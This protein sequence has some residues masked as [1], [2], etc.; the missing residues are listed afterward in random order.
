[1]DSIRLLGISGSPRKGAT[2]FVVRQA[3]EFAESLGGVETEFISLKG[4]K[5]NFCLHCDYCVR[6]KK[7]CIQKDDVS[8]LYPSMEAAD[9]W[10]L[11]TPVY[12]G[13]VSGQLKAVLDRC[14]AVVA[15]NPDVFRNKVG[16]AIAV[17]GDRIGGQEPAIMAIHA[18]YL[19]NKMI[20][21]SGGPYGSNLGGTVWS[22]DKKAEGAA[23]DEVGMR[24]VQ[25]T[26]ERLIEVAKLLKPEGDQ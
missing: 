11:A 3:L 8:E 16:A 17:G 2:A 7:G 4:K 13:S 15:R 22:R 21:V 14:R 6:T 25:R 12:Q 23:A 5:I 18:F 19:A 1:M 9:A 24:S 20:P 10:L 26:V